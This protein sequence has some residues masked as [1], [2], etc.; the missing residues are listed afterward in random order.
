LY[1]LGLRL[2]EKREKS[3]L[4]ATQR[5][6]T[7]REKEAEGSREGS[8]RGVWLLQKGDL[9]AAKR[10]FSGSKTAFC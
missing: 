8:G 1:I 2:A 3:S 10:R 4:W 6:Q 5:K 7:G 9:K